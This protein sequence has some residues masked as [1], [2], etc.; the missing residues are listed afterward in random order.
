MQEYI[1]EMLDDLPDDMNGEAVTQQQHICL[2]TT[3]TAES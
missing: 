2:S 1:Q 3:R